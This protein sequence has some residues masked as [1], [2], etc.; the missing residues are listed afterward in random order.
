MEKYKEQQPVYYC[1]KKYYPGKGYATVAYVKLR[2]DANINDYVK[3]FPETR[4][5]RLDT[6]PF[7]DYPGKNYK[8][9]DA[10]QFEE[11]SKRMKSGDEKATYEVKKENENYDDTGYTIGELKQ[12]LL[13][14]IPYLKKNV[15]D[16]SL[17]DTLK[18]MTDWG[19]WK[20]DSYSS[21]NSEIAEE[22]LNAIESE[23]KS[24]LSGNLTKDFFE[25]LE[26]YFKYH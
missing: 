24:D 16:W 9:L 21:I 1:I 3:M 5:Y 14:N 17:R 7:V 13:T 12:L 8:I 25:E 2:K 6:V 19:F 22:I 10:W 26:H 23:V 15:N 20:G 11:L 4:K 18:N